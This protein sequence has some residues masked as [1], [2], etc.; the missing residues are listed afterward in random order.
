ML[1][2]QGKKK[3]S[4]ALFLSHEIEKEKVEPEGD[5]VLLKHQGFILWKMA[6]G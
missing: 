3:V 5:C 2:H 4:H 6:G 1:C